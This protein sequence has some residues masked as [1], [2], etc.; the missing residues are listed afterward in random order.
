MGRYVIIP[1]EL[2]EIRVKEAKKAGEIVG[3]EIICADSNDLTMNSANKDKK[4]LR[5]INLGKFISNT[6]TTGIHSK[7]AYAVTFQMK[8]LRNFLGT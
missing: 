3:Y 8:E 4:V 6:L 1:D 5:L 7:K 2:C